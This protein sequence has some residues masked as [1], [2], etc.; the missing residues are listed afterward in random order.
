MHP[1]EDFFLRHCPL[2]APR[3]C[4]PHIH[5]FDEAHFEAVDASKLNEIK[6]FILISSPDDH[7]VDLDRR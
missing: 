1:I 7:R 4:I 3:I 5:V 2:Q 6:N